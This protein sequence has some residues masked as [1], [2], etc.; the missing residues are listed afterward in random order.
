MFT[1][2][3]DVRSDGCTFSFLTA[4]TAVVGCGQALQA[5]LVARGAHCTV[6]AVWKVCACAR[7]CLRI[8]VS[9]RAHMCAR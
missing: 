3:H 5:R 9:L 1:V 4:A 6:L 8:C 7:A 2:A